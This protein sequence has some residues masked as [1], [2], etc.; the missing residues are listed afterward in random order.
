MTDHTDDDERMLEELMAEA[1][2]DPTL[3]EFFR[4]DPKTLTLE[5]IRAFILSERK[6][7]AIHIGG[8]HG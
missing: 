4:R 5:E 8:D 3:D 1:A 6:A 2:R 7:R